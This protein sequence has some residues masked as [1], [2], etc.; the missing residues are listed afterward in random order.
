MVKHNSLTRLGFAL[1][2]LAAL[3]LGLN[4]PVKAQSGVD[5][6][7]YQS[8]EKNGLEGTGGLNPLDLIHRSQQFGR[9]SASEF[10]EESRGH[11]NNSAADF[12]RLQQQRL[13][14]QQQQ[15]DVSIDTVET[16]E[17]ITE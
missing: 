17:Q 7:G 6:Q 2:L 12:K 5:D 9:R 16:K 14:E 13:L 1:G 8:N 11:I 10:E 3:A 4:L 15:P